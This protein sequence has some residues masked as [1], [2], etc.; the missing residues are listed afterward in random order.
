[1]HYIN[2]SQK[3]RETTF[4]CSKIEF[5]MEK[6]SVVTNQL[7]ILINLWCPFL[8]YIKTT[9]PLRNQPSM[10]Y[11]LI[12]FIFFAFLISVL[13]AYR[14]NFRSGSEN[15]KLL[16]SIIACISGYYCIIKTS[17]WALHILSIFPY[18]HTGLSLYNMLL[19]I[20]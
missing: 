9:W 4:F 1:M 11:H 12:F 18:I 20:H 3:S 13:C 8:I 16:G 5:I 6:K 14:Y 2:K 19:V 10:C 15:S 17:M 7:E